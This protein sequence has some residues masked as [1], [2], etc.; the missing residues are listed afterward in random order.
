MRAADDDLEID[1]PSEIAALLDEAAQSTVRLHLSGKHEEAMALPLLRWDPSNGLLLRLPGLRAEAPAWLL[2]GPVHAHAVLDKVRIDFDLDFERRLTE[3]DG[4]PVLQLNVPSR[5]RRH[6]RRQAFRV[7][8]LSLH[9]PR[10]LLAQAGQ[11]RP[12][13]LTTQDLSAGG[14]ALVWPNAETAV[15][16]IGQLLD[17]VELEL[18]RE[19]R[20][21]VSLKV[22]HL[23]QNEEGQWVLGC[24]FMALTAQ[25]ERLLLLHLNQMQRRQRLLA[26]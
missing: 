20:M 21:P 22:E 15:P 8:P 11:S 18:E 25:A 6:Q 2:Q 9:H 1:H 19:L 14:V 7:A 12:L 24:A 5:V 3:A 16:E 10:A 4:L 13:R 17:G 23:R 26:R